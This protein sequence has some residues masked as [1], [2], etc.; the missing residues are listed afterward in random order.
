MAAANLVIRASEPPSPW[1]LI[2]LRNQLQGLLSDKI[3]TINRLYI[4]RRS[5]SK[6]AI[7]LVL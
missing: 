2:G 4:E 5:A 6:T 7:E 3:L 1:G